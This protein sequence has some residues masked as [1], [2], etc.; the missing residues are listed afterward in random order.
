MVFL[1]IYYILF[2]FLLFYHL[3]IVIFILLCNCTIYI[4]APHIAAVHDQLAQLSSADSDAWVQLVQ[5]TDRAVFAA[6]NPRSHHAKKA[7]AMDELHASIAS[8][9]ER[10]EAS[11]IVFPCFVHLRSACCT[12][13]CASVLIFIQEH[14][15]LLCPSPPLLIPSSMSLYPHLI[16]S[17]DFEAAARDCVC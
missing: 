4:G 7:A 13:V 14:C 1:C 12:Y 6:M 5:A 10:L 3:L 8:K 11:M 17:T 9:R 16:T 2:C 15:S